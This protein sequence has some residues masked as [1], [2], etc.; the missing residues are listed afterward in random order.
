MDDRPPF[1]VEVRS[2]IA[3]THL[4]TARSQKARTGNLGFMIREMGCKG[5]IYETKQNDD[6]SG[7]VVWTVFFLFM[8]MGMVT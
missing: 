7:T 5:D 6:G 3:V 8:R 1:A 4:A 2:L